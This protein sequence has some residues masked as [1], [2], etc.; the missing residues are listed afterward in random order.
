MYF[1]F[2]GLCI[3]HTHS[4]TEMDVGGSRDWVVQHTVPAAAVARAS[5]WLLILFLRVRARP[6]AAHARSANERAQRRLEHIS[7]GGL[8]MTLQNHDLRVQVPAWFG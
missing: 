5:R 6:P 2:G 8:S 1:F 3:M 7:R 4:H